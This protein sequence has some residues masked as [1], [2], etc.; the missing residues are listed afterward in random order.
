MSLGSLEKTVKRCVE[1]VKLELHA[2]RLPD[3]VKTD[4]K[5]TGCRHIVQHVNLISTAPIVQ[6]S[7]AAVNMGYL[8]LWI[9]VLVLTDARRGGQGNVVILFAVIEH[10]FQTDSVSNVQGFVK[11]ALLVINLQECVIM[12]VV[13]IELANIV[14]LVLTGYTTHSV[15]EYV[16]HV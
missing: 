2:M 15:A 4:V 7:A 9:R 16:D 12:D 8:A 1:N 14:K 3:C 11:T 13:C 5:I 10:M 6:V